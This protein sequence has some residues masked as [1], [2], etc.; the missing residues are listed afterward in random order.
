MQCPKET[1]LHFGNCFI[2]TKR[3]LLEAYND[4]VFGF[5]FFIKVFIIGPYFVLSVVVSVLIGWFICDVMR[6]KPF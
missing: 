1:I 6:A 2:L 4:H 3:L 5:F